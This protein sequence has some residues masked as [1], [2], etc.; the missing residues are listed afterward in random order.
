MRGVLARLGPFIGLAAFGAVLLA[1]HHAL[2]GVRYAELVRAWSAIPRADLAL[3]IVLALVSYVLLTGEDLL[4]LRYLGRRQPYRRVGIASFI[5]NALSHNVGFSVLS[6]GSVRMRLYTAWGMSAVEVTTVIGFGTATTWLGY[7]TLAGAS[8]LLEPFPLPSSVRLPAFSLRV[9]GGLLLLLVA[10]Y[11]GW[12]LRSRRPLTILGWAL[13]APAPR[14][15]AAQIALSALDWAAA[16]TALWILMPGSLDISM[17]AFVGLFLLAQVVGVASQTPGGLGV[18]ETVMLLFLGG[19][20]PTSALLGSLMAFRAVYYLLPLVLAAVSLGGFEAWRRREGLRRAAVLVGRFVP[21]IA[22]QVFAFTTFLAGAVLLLSGATPGVSGRLRLLHG[23]LPLPVI[24]VSHFLGSLAGVG[25]LVLARGLQRRLDAAYHATLVLLGA[26]AAFSLLKGFDYEEA[27]I[28]LVMLAALLPARRTFYRRASLLSQP[29]TPG[30]IAA[31]AVALAGSLWLGFFAYRHVEYRSQMWWEFALRGDAPR[32]LRASVGVA[33]AA[34]AVGIARLLRAGAPGRRVQAHAV[35][36]TIHSLVAQSSRTSA[37]LAM[38]GDKR[39]LLNA[40]GTGFVMYG[41]EGR[42]WVSLGNPVAAD[43]ATRRDLVWEFRELADRH[44]GWTVFYEVGREDLP[45]YLELGLVLLKLGEEARVPLT[46]FSLDG[47]E[48]KPLRYA[49][50]RLEREGC[51]FEIVPAAGVGALLPELRAISDEW[52][53][54]RG[55][56]EK[57]FSL[58]R[59]DD[60]YLEE[61]PLAVVRRGPRVLGFANVWMTATRDELSVDLMR[62]PTDAPPGVM[63]YL[64]VELMA[65]GAGEGFRWFNLGMAPLSGLEGRSLAPLWTRLGGLL[66]RHGENIYNFRGLRQFKEKFAPVWEPQY[67]A[68]PGGLALPVI[69]ANV[70]A[71]ISGGLKGAVTR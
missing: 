38:L 66:F 25:L 48:R 17:P 69:L 23:L 67:M 6:G 61:F 27:A 60:R 28:L 33:T 18:F 36:G 65:W 11:L 47:P 70:A 29:L 64:F 16:G 14:L 41:V 59:F 63:D 51:S 37:C 31:I 39:I 4:A 32:F 54:Q 55:A 56:R 43:P 44:G 13:P 68:S 2:R 26:G 10:A 46:A 34:L 8:F 40:E 53:C 42:S 12:S 71:L 22:P 57:G 35:D 50:R 24:E 9:L 30:W 5:A 15:A 3:A 20:A 7:A 62:H 19:R 49:R 21:A 1:L 45:V 58:G 52:L